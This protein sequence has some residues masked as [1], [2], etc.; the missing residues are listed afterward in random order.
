[1]CNLSIEKERKDHKGW[2]SES[3]RRSGLREGRVGMRRGCADVGRFLCLMVE[4]TNDGE[5][6]HICE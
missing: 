5:N 1:M 4:G 6:K 2:N 3:F